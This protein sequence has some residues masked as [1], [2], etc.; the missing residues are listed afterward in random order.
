[1]NRAAL[2]L[3]LFIFSPL[4]LAGPVEDA[5]ALIAKG[6][7]GEAWRLLYPIAVKEQDPVAQLMM[8]QLLLA[9]PSVDENTSKA[10]KFFRAAE[11][12]GNRAAPRFI[13]IAEQQMRYSREAESR[14]NA[15]KKLYQVAERSH[16]ELAEKLKRGFVDGDGNVRSHRVDVFVQGDTPVT[17]LVETL[18]NQNADL[19][20]ETIL[21]FHLVFD[22]KDMG[23]ANPFS[24]GYI[25]PETGFNPDIDG[26]LA[27]EL[28]VRSLPAIVLREHKNKQP[29]IVNFSQLNN[30]AN[31]WRSNEQ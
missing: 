20:D 26:V 30:W 5:R 9:S 15:S 25:P 23:S 21:K 22:A 2:L 11:R 19:A 14:V 18:F 24:D 31:R 29:Q 28:G 3:C 6:Q 13:E 10:L 16:A 4:V 7:K 12:N 27:S 8:G 17:Q 1:M